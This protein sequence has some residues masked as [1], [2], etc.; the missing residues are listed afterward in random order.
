MRTDALLLVLRN[1]LCEGTLQER[2]FDQLKCRLR[3][4]CHLADGERSLLEPRCPV[5]AEGACDFVVGD[6][7][8]EVLNS[9]V[10]IQRRCC[11]EDGLDRARGQN[12]C[13]QGFLKGLGRIQNVLHSIKMSPSVIRDVGSRDAGGCHL[14]NFHVV[15]MRQPVRGLRRLDSRIRKAET[16]RRRA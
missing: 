7:E 10:N 11:I 14:P 16:I 3:G 6:D 2:G 4:V 8:T 13:T 12:C 1:L 5:Q 9:R 15:T